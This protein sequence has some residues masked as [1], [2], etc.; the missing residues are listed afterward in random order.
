[1]TRFRRIGGSWSKT[2]YLC[3]GREQKN[4]SNRRRR[5]AGD[6]PRRRDRCRPCILDV[7][8]GVHPFRGVRRFVWL[9]LVGVP[10]PIQGRWPASKRTSA[11]GSRRNRDRGF[12]R[13]S[14]RGLFRHSTTRDSAICGVK[15]PGRSRR[16]IARS[17]T[18]ALREIASVSIGRSRSVDHGEISS[19]PQID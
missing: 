7:R 19:P 16:T 6:R 15:S 1:M 4:R 18:P 13:G 5:W 11:I 10:A 12:V 9:R 2:F 3:R 17:T 8:P 14:R